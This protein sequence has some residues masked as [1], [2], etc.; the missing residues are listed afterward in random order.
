MQPELRSTALPRFAWALY[1]L[2]MVMG[3]AGLIH[4]RTIG[5]LPLHADSVFAAVLP[6]CLVVWL[7]AGSYL[8]ASATKR[9]LLKGPDDGRVAA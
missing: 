3:L 1:A 6:G 8:L 9:G 5:G 2:P 7:L 4:R